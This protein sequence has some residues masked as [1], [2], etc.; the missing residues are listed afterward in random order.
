MP[1]DVPQVSGPPDDV[2][3]QEKDMMKAKA[4]PVREPIAP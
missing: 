3:Q 2:K 4:K 1:K